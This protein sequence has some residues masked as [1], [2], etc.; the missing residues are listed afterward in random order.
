MSARMYVHYLNVHYKTRVLTFLIHSETWEWKN[1]K[2]NWKGQSSEH[3]DVDYFAP[4]YKSHSGLCGKLRVPYQT[5]EERE[6]RFKCLC[7]VTSHITTTGQQHHNNGRWY[8]HCGFQSTIQFFLRTSR[9]CLPS[10]RG[11][12][13]NMKLQLSTLCY[14]LFFVCQMAMTYTSLLHYICMYTHMANL[15][16]IF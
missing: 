15:I 2:K 14:G 11:G 16:L 13:K 12:P 10:G 6:S 1:S 9:R 4:L 7:L 3:C 8:F 5:E